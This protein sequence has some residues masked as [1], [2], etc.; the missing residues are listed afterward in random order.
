MSLLHE[1]RRA[2]LYTRSLL[3]D[4]LNHHARPKT[5]REMKDRASRCLR[6]FPALE[7]DGKPIWSRV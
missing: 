3:F 2:L 4:L 6:H 5:V 7:R 1:Q